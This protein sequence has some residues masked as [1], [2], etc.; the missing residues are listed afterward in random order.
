MIV[1]FKTRIPNIE[2][3]TLLRLLSTLPGLTFYNKDNIYK[4]VVVCTEEGL[5][6]KLINEEIVSDCSEKGLEDMNWYFKGNSV[7]RTKKNPE[8]FYD[9]DITSIEYPNEY[10]IIRNLNMNFIKSIKDKIYFDGYECT[11][12]NKEGK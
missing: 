7:L 8:G 10:L 12:I 2:G 11:L 3:V 4:E 9:L 1:N 6:Y 5:M